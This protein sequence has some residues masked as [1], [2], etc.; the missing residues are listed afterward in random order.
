MSRITTSIFPPSNLLI[1]FSAAGLT[2]LVDIW[3]RLRREIFDSYRP[4]LHYMRGPGPR[5]R[6]KHAHI[7]AVLSLSRQQQICRSTRYRRLA[8]V[9][10]LRII[11]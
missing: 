6:E 5:W 4:D 11:A 2:P 3:R 1:G 7:T 8:R 10:K 9:L